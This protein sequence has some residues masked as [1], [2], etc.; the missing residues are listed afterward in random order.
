MGLIFSVALAEIYF[1]LLPAL[2]QQYNFNQFV[3]G[4]G[5]IYTTFNRQKEDYRVYR[6]S[7]ILGYEFVPNVNPMINSFGIIGKERSIEKDRGIYR[8]L[9]LGDSITVQNWY[10]EALEAKLN[11]SNPKLKYK[12]ELWNCGV[13]GYRVA[14]YA[15]YLK[16]KGIGYHPDMVIIGF[17]LNDSDTSYYIYYKDKHKFT[18]CYNPALAL[19][20]RIYLDSFL[21]KHSY[22]Y[23]FLT[24]KI[25]RS[26]SSPQSKYYD[27]KAEGLYYLKII[28]NICQEE[29]IPLLE[30]IF[31]YL[32]PLSEYYDYE[33]KK[34]RVITEVLKT[35][36]IDYVD[37]HKYFPEE[38]RYALRWHSN[39]YVHPSIRGH[40]IAADAI[41]AHLLENYFIESRNVNLT[42]LKDSEGVASPK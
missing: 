8:I 4:D 40:E 16:N 12:F 39:D 37:L 25:D 34:Y 3:I 30:V 29:K 5:P 26:L 32:K 7:D 10:V 35:L 20:K 41:Y 19:S 6:P 13:P 15:N 27:P 42:E 31:P 2:S 9:V 28:K 24:L 33:M 1:R 11:N 36:D 21:F 38:K 23:R 17:C 22:L 18:I 14:Q